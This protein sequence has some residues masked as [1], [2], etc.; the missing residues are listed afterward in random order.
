MSVGAYGQ[1]I[2]IYIKPTE[3]NDSVD[4]FY[5][6]HETRTYDAVKNSQFFRLDSSVLQPCRRDMNG[7]SGVIDDVIEGM[8]T[9]QLPLNVFNKK[10]FYT[11]YIQPKEVEAKIIDVGNLMAFPNVR[12]IVLDTEDIKNQVLKTRAKD[13][14]ALIGYRVI[15]LDDTG[16]RMPYYRIVTSSNKTEA[17]IQAPNSSSDKSVAYRYDDGSSYIFMTLSPTTANSFKPNSIPYIGKPGQRIILVNTLFEPIAIDIEMETHNADTISWM[18]ENS[19]LRDLDN[20]L[21]TTYNDRDEIYEQHE[22]YTLKDQ[23]S[24]VPV[25]E[26]KKKRDGNIDFTQ[27]ITDK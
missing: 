14:D 18:L 20:G 13:N 1:T 3:V 26:V 16:N 9:L 15:L 4:I 22:H 23:T 6:Y 19:Q 27:T 25:F 17:V 8:Y 5:A 24:G 7:N 21:V 10:G 12:G 11:V 2:P